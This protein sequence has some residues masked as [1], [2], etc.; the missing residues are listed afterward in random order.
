MTYNPGQDDANQNGIGDTCDDEFT[1]GE[2]VSRNLYVPF[3]FLKFIKNSRSSQD[4]TS[5]SKTGSIICHPNAKSI[6]E[7]NG[8]N[9]CE[10]IKQQFQLVNYSANKLTGIC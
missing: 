3:E 7:P 6:Q 4:Q 10:V 1:V 2:P 8:Y 5:M 9:T